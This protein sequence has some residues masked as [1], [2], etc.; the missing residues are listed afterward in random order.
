MDVGYSCTWTTMRP[1]GKNK[2]LGPANT[3]RWRH[4]LVSNKQGPEQCVQCAVCVRQDHVHT[5]VD[6][7]GLAAAAGREEGSEDREPTLYRLPFRP[8]TLVMS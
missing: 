7:L 3:E 5:H 2:Q 6:C 4:R 1:A 8:G